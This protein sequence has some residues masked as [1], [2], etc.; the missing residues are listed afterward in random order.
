VLRA[1]RHIL[2]PGRPRKRSTPALSTNGAKVETLLNRVGRTSSAPLDLVR[3]TPKTTSKKATALFAPAAF[4]ILPKTKSSLVPRTF[5]VKA[6]TLETENQARP[7]SHALEARPQH[8]QVLPKRRSARYLLAQSTTPPLKP[9]RRASQHPGALE[10]LYPQPALNKSRASQAPPASRARP[11]PRTVLQPRALPVT[12][13]CPLKPSP[14]SASRVAPTMC[15]R[16][17]PIPQFARRV[18]WEPIRP[19]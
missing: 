13:P 18:L 1:S 14:W 3:K 17:R 19:G 9:S 5:I 15:A 2:R 10:D 12:T 7:P 8:L 6:A 16:A 4:T 11:S